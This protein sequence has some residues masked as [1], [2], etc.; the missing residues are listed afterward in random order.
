[1]PSRDSDQPVGRMSGLYD[2]LRYLQENRRNVEVTLGNRPYGAASC[3]VLDELIRRVSVVI[4]RAA[5]DAA[6][7]LRLI[8]NHADEIVSILRLVAQTLEDIAAIDLDAKEVL[9][10]QRQPFIRLI[11]RIESEGYTVD[12]NTF[13][14]VTDDWDWSSDAGD[15]PTVQKQLEVEK[16]SRAEQAIRY[17][18]RLERM[19]AAFTNLEGAFAERLRNL[20][21]PLPGIV[22]PH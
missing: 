21:K 17:Q 14:T 3:E 7:P 19:D 12:T 8:K 5:P 11:E 15:N 1:M 2:T 16:A 13:T 6:A 4:D 18:Q 10:Q 20:I 22:R 9:V